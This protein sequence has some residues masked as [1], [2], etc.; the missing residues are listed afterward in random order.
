MHHAGDTADEVDGVEH[1]DGLGA[2]GHGYRHAVAL[3]DTDGLQSLGTLLYL[4]DHPGIGRGLAHEVKRHVV[5]ISGGHR[6]H[7]VEHRALEV[8]QMY[9]N[10]LGIR[11]PRSLN[12]IVCHKFGYRVYPANIQ[13][14]SQKRTVAVIFQSYISA[15]CRRSTYPM[16][17]AASRQSGQRIQ[18]IYP[19]VL[20]FREGERNG[21]GEYAAISMVSRR[22]RP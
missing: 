10:S 11:I 17:N 16:K 5:G 6:S 12:S 15:V 19:D 3:A 8:L 22:A 7:H 13:N 20:L 1:V 4:P 14:N 21:A 9:G 2:V 18:Y